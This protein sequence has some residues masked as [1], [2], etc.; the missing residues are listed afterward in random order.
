MAGKWTEIAKTLGRREDEPGAFQSQVNELKDADRGKALDELAAKYRQVRKEKEDLETVAKGIN[1]REMAL[2]ALI[3]EVFVS[4]ARDKPFYF[5]DGARIE[6]S[7]QISVR[8]ADSDAIV[9]WMKAN[10]YERMLKIG[11]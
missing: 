3:S 11:R 5:T 4:E 8:A 7:D 1:A 9:A 6:V 2:A 10:G